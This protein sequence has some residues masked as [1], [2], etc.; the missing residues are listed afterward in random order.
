[1]KNLVV[2]LAALAAFSTPALAADM[3]AK[4]P[5]RAAPVAYAP[6]WT[7]IGIS[8]GF[9]YGLAQYQHSENNIAA[10]FALVSTGQ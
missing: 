1:M 9:G 6:S 7:G 10:P 2:T 8:G 3:A 5:M 4:A